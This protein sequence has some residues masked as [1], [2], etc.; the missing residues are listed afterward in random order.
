MK[1]ML[2]QARGHQV[3]MFF[4]TEPLAKSYINFLTMNV[5]SS[6]ACRSSDVGGSL[7]YECSINEFIVYSNRIMYV[8]YW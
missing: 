2:Y 8:L 5:F 6:I 3:H 1:K 7:W 4:F